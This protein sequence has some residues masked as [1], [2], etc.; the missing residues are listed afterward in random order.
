MTAPADMARWVQTFLEA[1]A[2]ELDAASNTQLAYARDL[3]DFA[4]WLGHRKLHFSSATQ[5][6]VEGYLID[7]EAQGL[8]KSTR[9]RRLSAI[10]Q[11][12]R[13]GFEEGWR[14]DNPAIQIKGPGRDKRLPKTLEIAEVDRLIAAARDSGADTARN[15]CLMELLYATGM[16]VTE[17]V[18]L[19]VSA[20]RGNP[21]MLLVR[22]KGGKERM[23]PLSPPARVAMADWLTAWDA[24]QDLA[25]SK[26]IPPA[27]FL[28]PSRGKAGHLTRHRFYTLIKE[29]ALRG[30]VSPAKVTPHT[31]RHAFATHLLAG[32]A[33]LRA[34]QTMLGHA[35]VATT[36]IY[37]HVL[38]ERLRD[39]VLTHH[40]LAKDDDAS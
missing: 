14:G 35:D 33:D 28:F 4:G 3:Q 32:G 39:L 36:E 16:R 15:T 31:L 10:K 25:K 27:R 24:A 18:S 34:I 21:A 30:G 20:A 6:H 19:P 5:D 2:A 29:L 23:V 37:T 7:C 40:P 9:A 13:F 11:L 8:A 12:F 22:G 38:D 1:Q 26:G 17:L